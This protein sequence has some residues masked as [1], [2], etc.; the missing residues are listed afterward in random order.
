VVARGG[1]PVEGEPD[2]APLVI[3]RWPSEAAFRDYANLGFLSKFKNRIHGGKV[4]YTPKADQCRACGLCI[5]ACPEHAI[6]L[7]K[8]SP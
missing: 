1:S 8:A 5:K 4:S 3:Q 2:F 6:K 7:V